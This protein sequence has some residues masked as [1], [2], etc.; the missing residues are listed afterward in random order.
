M[1]S[2]QDHSILYGVDVPGTKFSHAI[3]SSIAT[4]RP[5]TN[6]AGSELKGDHLL[7]SLHRSDKCTQSLHY[8]GPGGQVGEWCEREILVRESGRERETETSEYRRYE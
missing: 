7:R 4:G 6:Y 2:L 1:K 8:V 5:H 3:Y